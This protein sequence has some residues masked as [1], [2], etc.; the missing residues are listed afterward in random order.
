MPNISKNRIG[1]ILFIKCFRL[2]IQICIAK[3]PQP[4]RKA[5]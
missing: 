4:V 3:K 5:A 2:R 1:G